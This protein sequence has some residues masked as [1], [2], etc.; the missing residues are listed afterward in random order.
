M[1]VL[2]TKLHLPAPRRRSVQRARLT[3]QLRAD[4]GGRSRLVLVAAPAGFGKTTLLTQWLSAVEP[5]QRR[6]AWLALGS[7]TL[8]FQGS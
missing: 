4:E 6:A 3:E 8:T 7:A 1:P 5:S 2:G